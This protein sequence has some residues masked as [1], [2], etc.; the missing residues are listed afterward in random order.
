[1]PLNKNYV[2]K[3]YFI[4][5]LSLGVYKGKINSHQ[6]TRDVTILS[7]EVKVVQRSNRDG[8]SGIKSAR[9]LFS[10]NLVNTKFKRKS[11]VIPQ[12]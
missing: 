6:S 8:R 1:M 5:E 4:L 9:F 7:C 12:F 10:T 3:I 2:F 11:T